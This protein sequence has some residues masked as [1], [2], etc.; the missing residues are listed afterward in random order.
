MYATIFSLMVSAHEPGVLM[1]GSD[2]GRV[3]L[4]SDEGASWTEVTPP[5]LPKFSQVT[6][7]AESPHT[8]G[9]V[10]MTVAR[11]KM[12]DYAAYVFKST[13]LGGT[14]TRIDDGIPEND[15][16][17]VIREDPNRQGL[18][19][20]GTERGIFVSFD[21]G[22]S[23]QSLQCNLPVTPIYDFVVKDTDLVVATHG[24]SF[25]ILDD[26]T[27]VHQ[28]HDAVAGHDRYLLKP[29]ATVR[30]PLALFADFQG[31]TSGK[32]Y[33]VTI[34]QNATFYV[35]EDETGFKRKRVIDAGD[36][37]DRGV[38]I[39]Y[40]L[41]SDG[42]GEATLTIADADG[43]EIDTWSNDIPADE[44]DRDG[45][46]ITAKA[47]MNRFQWS[48][49]HRSGVKMVDSDF[50]DR[51]AGPLALPG[52]YQ[53]TLTVGEWSMTQPFE[54]VKDPRVTTS[55]AD[56]AEQLEL[57]LAIRDKL[58]DT[59]SAV[60]TIRTLKRQLADWSTR[61]ADQDG[62]TDAVSSAAALTDKL[63]EIEGR[64]VQAEFTS[65][66]DSLNYREQLFEKLGGLAPIVSSADAR[67]TR[68]SHQ[69][70]DKLA[71]QIDEQ[72]AA[73]GG[74]T[75]GDLAAFNA[76]LVALGVDIVAG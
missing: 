8:A 60:N 53:V 37:I 30:S 38:A 62:A 54:L 20:V 44:A 48:M 34:G 24:R 52:A 7:I 39:T 32:N 73:L 25:W 64:L 1:A 45:M 29:R 4:T 58:S 71:G 2:D 63:A 67:P 65:E 12:G 28:I 47:G 22:S 43:N 3:H 49:N 72:L 76:Q 42:I 59:A 10:Y 46:Y 16:C 41:N 51:P 15:F 6:M 57:M 61:L 35:E 23:W 19:Y 14:W 36:D 27:Q 13:D 55:D 68:Q 74:V 31:S 33:H 11:H 5:D 56:L 66:G 17:R 21:D 50:H 9:T 75:S 18:L 26:L 40:Y 70:F 69:V